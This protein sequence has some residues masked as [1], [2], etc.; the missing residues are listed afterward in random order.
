MSKNQEKVPNGCV[1]PFGCFKTYEGKK[2]FD[3]Y[4]LDVSEKEVFK[5]TGEKDPETG[6]DLGVIEKKLIVKKIDIH[7][8]LESQRDSVGVEAY[9][10]ALTLQGQSIDDFHTDVNDGVDDFSQMPDTLEGVLTAGDKAREVFDNLDPALKGSHT[11]IEGFLNS[12]TQESLDS[13]IKS[14]IE[15]LTGSSNKEGE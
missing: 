12:L 9:V 15:A 8:Y 3:K 10:K 13:Y 6:E 4:Y 5:S 11:T 1:G 2:D 14:R 7:D